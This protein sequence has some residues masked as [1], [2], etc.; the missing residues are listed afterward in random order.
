MNRKAVRVGE[1]VES[2]TLRLAMQLIATL[3]P[4]MVRGCK[5]EECQL[6]RALIKL[7]RS[8]GFA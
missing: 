7:Y 3:D 2:N 6:K 8:S 5:C 4:V 1:E